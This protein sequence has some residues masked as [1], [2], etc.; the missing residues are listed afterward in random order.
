LIDAHVWNTSKERKRVTDKE[1]A[2]IVADLAVAE[3]T[4]NAGFHAIHV[5]AEKL[6]AEP[7]FA[8]L[9]PRNV[10]SA[11]GAHLI[12]STFVAQRMLQIARDTRDPVAAVA[13]LRIIP[14]LEEGRGGAVKTLYGV[15]CSERVALSDDIVLIPFS[16]LS[17]SSMRSYVLDQYRGDT[18]TPG[19]RA[20]I[21]PPYAALYRAGTIKP[22]TVGSDFSKGAPAT[23]FEDL[24]TAA[25]LLA[26]VPTAVPLEALHWYHYDDP[27]VAMLCQF[28]ISWLGA[29]FQPSGYVEPAQITTEAVTGLLSGYRNLNKGDQDRVTLALQRLIR[30]RC[31]SNPGNRAIDLA[32]A[33]E[34][35]FMNADSGEHSYKN[36]LRCARLVRTSLVDRRAVFAQVKK[37]YDM[38][39][40]MVHRGSA[41][42]TCNVNGD[43]YTASDLVG[44]VDVICAESIRRFLALGGIPK[45][46]QD[47]ELG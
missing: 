24:N 21:Q 2:A 9:P 18:G 38:R 23:W 3:A 37:L 30:A 7:E 39:S 46:W 41:P 22:L 10:R 16:D 40:S 20:F 31:Q 5:L 13:W 8:G 26:L 47:T 28:G 1:L 17:A 44:S 34:V 14:R 11:L 35:L 36:S 29:E 19:F 32:I 25:L 33:L 12:S 43:Q 27:D 42:S 4:S 15:K 45:E 6:D